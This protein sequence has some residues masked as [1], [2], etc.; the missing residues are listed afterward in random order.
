MI[1]LEN[2]CKNTNRRFRL[3]FQ[4]EAGFGR[5]NKPKSC[6]CGDNIRPAVPCYR[7][8]EYTYA[9]GAVS[10]L[11]GSMIS[12]V[13]PKCNTYCMNLFLKEVSKMYPNDQILM[14]ADNAA[15]H[16]R[17]NGLIIPENIE[18]FP[19]LSYTPELNPIEMI[20]EEIREN[21]LRINCLKGGWAVSSTSYYIQS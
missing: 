16:T 13:L 10:P 6:W 4:D 7:I 19:L 17:S 20:W 18:I 5:T 1:E 8:R 3:M 12:L 2:C 11:D 15:W 21:F 14:V 9:Y